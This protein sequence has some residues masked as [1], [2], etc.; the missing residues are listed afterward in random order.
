MLSLHKIRAVRK[1]VSHD[2]CAD[3]YAS[4]ILIRDAFYGRSDVEFVFVQHGTPEAKNL[5]AEPNMLF[6][7]MVPPEDR[8]Q[9]FVDAGALVL[10]H[11]AKARHIVEAFGEDGIFADEVTEPGVCGAVLA[12]RHVWM[13][14]RAEMAIQR[15]FA[16]RFATL[17]GIRDTWQRNDPSWIEACKQ[18]YILTF[19][20]RDKWMEIPLSTL[21]STWATQFA[22]LGDVLLRKQ[23]ETTEKA[24]EKSYRFTTEAETR[25][26]V[27]EGVRATSDVAEEVGDQADLI[28]GFNYEVNNREGIF[29]MI[30]STRSRGSYDCGALCVYYGGGGHTRAAGFNVV[31]DPYSNSPISSNPYAAVKALVARY[32]EE[33]GLWL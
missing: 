2:R 29:K 4:A 1:V 9:E 18:S 15:I 13:P 28:V 14:F 27:F 21:A 22:W 17:A 10:D 26:I 25:V 12:Y 16:E 7:D 23:Q 30:L 31:F 5:V 8:L 20:P 33:A 11:H 24:L 3:G 6:V 32:E 19:Y